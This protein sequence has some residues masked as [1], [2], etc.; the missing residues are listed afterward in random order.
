MRQI[1][2]T[3]LVLWQETFWEVWEPLPIDQKAGWIVLV[4]NTLAVITLIEILM[5]GT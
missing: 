3:N 1:I 5:L 2:L 4:S